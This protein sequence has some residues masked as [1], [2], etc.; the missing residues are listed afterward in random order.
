[1]I[2]DGKDQEVKVKL[3]EASA[4]GPAPR[5]G[6]QGGPAQGGKLGIAIMPLTPDVARQLGL[7]PDTTGL[8]VRDVDPSG[9]AADAGI[10]P[11]DV[12]VEANREP[13]RSGADLQKA[14][15]K[16]GQVVLLINRQGRTSFV[17]VRP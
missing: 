6:D 11:G 10:Q 15:A 9:P 1:M 5:Q 14:M 12:I 13:V 16:G 2:R 7:R 4:T 17:T 8:V 3:G